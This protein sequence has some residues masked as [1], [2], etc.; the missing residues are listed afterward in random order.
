MGIYKGSLH[1]AC[2]ACHWT[3]ANFV[4]LFSLD[5]TLYSWTLH[6]QLFTLA[7]LESMLL[8]RSAAIPPPAILMLDTCPS[9]SHA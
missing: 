1:L 3:M 7:A 8:H 5:T 4:S 2:L 6:L 9:E